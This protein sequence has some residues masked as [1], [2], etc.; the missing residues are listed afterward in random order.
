VGA[1]RADIDG[2]ADQGAAYVFTRSGSS[3]SQQAKLVAGDGAAEDWFGYSVAL[4]GNTAVVGALGADI[5]GNVDQGAAYVFTHSGSTWSEQAK[6]TTADGAA[7]DFFGWSVA[8]EGDTALVG[9]PDADVEGSAHQGAVYVFVHSGT[10]WSEQDKLTAG[11][12]TTYDAFGVSAALDGD[13][14]LV[15]PL[16]SN[17]TRAPHTFFPTVAPVGVSKRSLRPTTEWLLTTSA[18]PDRLRNRKSQNRASADA[19]RHK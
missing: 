7:A 13:T 6:L 4:D 17:V 18:Q 1:H 16:A 14:A 2:H 8:L 10:D 11:D 5:D 15:G 9:A 12:G 3:W 19:S